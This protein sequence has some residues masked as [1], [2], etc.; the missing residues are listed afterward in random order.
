[1]SST[2][3][4]SAIITTYNQSHL[5]TRCLESVF[6]QTVAPIEII[7]VDDGSRD[8]PGAVLKPY[9]DRVKFLPRSVN[10]GGPSAPRNDGMRAATGKWVAFLDGDD[11]WLPD[12]LARQLAVIAQHPDISLVYCDCIQIHE[13][14]K[15][16][17]NYHADKSPVS[18]Q[19]LDAL[20]EEI[21][22]L[23]STVLLNREAALRLGGFDETLHGVED[24]DLWLRL[25]M[26]GYSMSLLPQALVVYQRQENSLS[27]NR[28]KI[29]ETQVR[30]W[31]KLLRAQI[32]S[33][34]R[35]RVKVY[36][37]GL[38]LELGFWLRHVDI[39][40]AVRHSVASLRYRP[41]NLLGWKITSGNL[42]RI[43]KGRLPRARNNS[44]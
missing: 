31:N 38:H 41:R 36:L 42:M 37:A 20:I 5:L 21:F 40:L 7:V 17:Q 29:L 32:T 3:T 15:Q 39:H 22:I 28:C 11:Q 13:D 24:H 27:R 19:I 2:P 35:S 12:K 14:G 1:M 44:Q 10:S 16:F 23:P 26:K 9:G 33:T 34:Q 6:S 4:V 30:A 8:N 25:S 18:G 43:V